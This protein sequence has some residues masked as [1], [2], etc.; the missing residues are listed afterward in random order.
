MAAAHPSKPDPVHVLV[1]NAD[2]ASRSKAH[3]ELARRAAARDDKTMAAFHF[4]EALD[5]DPTDEVTAEELRRMTPQVHKGLLA[6]M[7]GR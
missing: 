3:Q 5:L 6:R 2:P 7:F 1:H 4:K